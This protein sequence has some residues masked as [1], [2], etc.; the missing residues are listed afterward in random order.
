MKSEIVKVLVILFSIVLLQACAQEEVAG[1]NDSSMGSLNTAGGV[2]YAE[3]NIQM[4]IRDVMNTFIDPNADILWEA[5]SYENSLEG[6]VVERIP[7][8]DEDWALLRRSA[9]GIIEGANSLMIPGRRVA[10]PGSTTDYPDAEYEPLEVEVKLQED[11][12]SWIGFAQGL[13]ATTLQ[14]LNA[15]DARN[16]DAY[17][18]AGGAIDDA[19]TACHQQYWYRSELR[20]SP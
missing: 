15:I 11:R 8:T 14:A 4:T 3:F 7:E 13:Q 10:P 6:G 16:L 18:E 9:I 1:V 20:T 5:V 17:T 12:V 19:C 2:P